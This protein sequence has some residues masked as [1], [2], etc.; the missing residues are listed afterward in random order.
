[1]ETVSAVYRD[2]RVIEVFPKFGGPP[3]LFDV[4]RWTDR[5]KFIKW[6]IRYMWVWNDNPLVPTYD[7]R[8]RRLDE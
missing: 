1:V 3:V 8:G 2:D 4:S 6:C 7:Q 5:W